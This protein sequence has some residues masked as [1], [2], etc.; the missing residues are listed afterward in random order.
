MSNMS[1]CMFENTYKDLADCVEELRSKSV[2]ELENNAGQYEKPYIKDLIY[3]CKEVVDM[4][5]KDDINQF[6]L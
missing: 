6:S 2:D 4:F 1:Y 5:D 3:L